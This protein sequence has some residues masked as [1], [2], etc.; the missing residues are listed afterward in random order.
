MSFSAHSVQLQFIYEG[1]KYL[2][3][4]AVQ[5]MGLKMAAEVSRTDAFYNLGFKIHHIKITQLQQDIAFSSDLYI[6]MILNL[7]IY[8][9]EHISKY[10]SYMY[11]NI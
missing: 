8:I 5:E 6:I 9:L 11:N 7:K 10:T 2:L 4:E 3:K 1:E